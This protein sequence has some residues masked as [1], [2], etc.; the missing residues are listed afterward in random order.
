MQKAVRQPITQIVANAGLEPAAI[1]EKV[2]ANS[3]PNF[4]YDALKVV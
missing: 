4:G 2:L 1:V 3:E